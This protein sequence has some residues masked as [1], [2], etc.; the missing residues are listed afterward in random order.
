[1]TGSKV[2]QQDMVKASVARIRKAT[3]L[4]VVVGFGISTP[5]QAAQIGS[6]ADGA[7]VGSAIVTRIEKAVTAGLDKAK[8]T[9]D[10]LNFCQSLAK[11]LHGARAGNVVG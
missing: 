5:E 11:S 9:D 6:F 7:A 4:P 3:N 8:L 1:M 10:V 2:V